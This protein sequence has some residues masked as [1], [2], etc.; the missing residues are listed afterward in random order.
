MTGDERGISRG[1]GVDGVM[2][3]LLPSSLFPVFLFFL[4]S[5]SQLLPSSL[6]DLPLFKGDLNCKCFFFSLT[7]G[8]KGSLEDRMGKRDALQDALLTAPQTSRTCGP[9]PAW[10]EGEGFLLAATG[11]VL[12]IMPGP[13]SS[14]GPQKNV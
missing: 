7:L 5:F 4:T 11:S 13:Q 2:P 9:D 8:Y 14:K 10:V 1:R 12:G 3:S 6:R